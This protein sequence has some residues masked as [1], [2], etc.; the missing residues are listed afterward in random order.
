MQKKKFTKFISA[1]LCGCLI[2][3]S[4]VPGI[5]A[6]GVQAQDTAESEW[7]EVSAILDGYPGVYTM[8]TKLG[9]PWNTDCSPD[10]PLM[11]NG[12]VYAFMDPSSQTAQNVY[13][14]RS[15]LWTE[16]HQEGNTSRYGYTTLGEISVEKKTGKNL[17]LNKPTTESGW[18]VEDQRAANIVDG[19]PDTMWFCSKD[20]NG[21][22]TN[23]WAVVD[24]EEVCDISRWVVKHAEAGG[25]TSNLNSKDFKLQYYDGTGTPDGAVEDDW[26][27][28]DSVTDNTLA[29]TDR[30]LENPIKAR[31]VRILVTTPSQD[32][33]V[34]LR[35]SELELYSES[36]NKEQE[37]QQVQDV[38][39]AEVVA[40]S[41]DG[42][43]MRN[44]V[45][46]K[47]NVVVTEIKNITEKPLDL[48]VTSGTKYGDITASIDEDKNVMTATKSCGFD[49]KEK[50]A[51]EV[52]M[53]SGF[54]G[55][56]DIQLS[57]I[58]KGINQ[59]E[60][61]LEPNQTVTMVTAVEGGR[62]IQTQSSSKDMADATLNKSLNS[63]NELEEQHREWWK[64]YW[65]KS[66]VNFYNDSINRYYYGMLYQL[67]CAS[68]V[69]SN[70]NAGVAP[71]LFPWTAA[72]YPKWNGAYFCNTDATRQ[73]HPL[74]QANR[75]EGLANFENVVGDYWEPARKLAQD[76]EQLN[77]VNKGNKRPAFEEGIRGVL[78]T[79]VICPWG[80]WN[81]QSVQDYIYMNQPSNASSMLMPM[82]KKWQYTQ[83]EDYLRNWLYPK[84]KDV[85]EFWIDYAVEENGKYVIYG[86]SHEGNA[87]RNAIFDL[88]AA[89]Y[90]ISNTIEASIELGV[91]EQEREEWQHVLDNLSDYPTVTVNGKTRFATCEGNGFLNA[92]PVTVQG[93]YYFDA[94]DM[95]MEK[96]ERDKVFNYLDAVGSGAWSSSRGM[97]AAIRA[98]YQI[99]DPDDFAA[100]YINI[101]PDHWSG[102]RGN[103]TC[104]DIGR[105]AWSAVLQETLLQSQAGFLQLFPNW[106]HEGEFTRLRAKGAFL[107]DAYQ[108]DFD[109]V[110]Y[111]NV[112]SEKGKDCSVLNPWQ[113]DDQ[114][115]KVLKD[116]KEVKTTVEKNSLGDIY[117]F[118]TEAGANY[119]LVP[120]NGV[121]IKFVIEGSSD[122]FMEDTL[123]LTVKTTVDNPTVK[124]E[125]SDKEIAT[126]DANGVVT[127]KK[128][129]DVT[130]TAT[131]E[132]EEN[133]TASHI[134]HIVEKIPGDDFSAVAD[135]EENKGNDGPASNT[136][137]GD[138]ET[139]WHSAY[140]SDKV[141]PDIKNNVNN[142]ITI[143]LGATYRIGRLDYVP[144]QNGN[145]GIITKYEVWCSNEPEGEN[146]KKVSEGSWAED[147]TTKSAQ[148]DSVSCRRIR[149]RAME[150]NSGKNQW[151]TAA[152]FCVYKTQQDG[153]NEDFT[154][155][156]NTLELKPGMKEKLSVITSIENPK[157]NWASSN[158]DIVI[159]GNDGTLLALKEGTAD[160]TAMIAEIDL[161]AKC[162]V[163]V[164][165]ETGI[166]VAPNGT[167]TAS[168]RSENAYKAIN[169]EWTPSYEG[170]TGPGSWDEE[171]ARWLQIDLGK[172]YTIERWLLRHDGW[173]KG[174][175]GEAETK[176]DGN[177]G[178]Y[179]LQ[180][181]PD[182]ENN[183][184][185]VDSN[186]DNKSNTTD[187]MLETPVTGRYFRIYMEFP[188]F[189][190]ETGWKWKT[191]YA[192][193][194]QVELYAVPSAPEAVNVVEIESLEEIDV[195]YG[196]GFDEINLPDFITV[197]LSNEMN[198]NFPVK[199]DAG[200][201]NGNQEGT[202][203]I[204]GTLELP[205]G[206]VN[207]ENLAATVQVVV[208]AP[209]TNKESL[210]EI[211][212]YALTLNT[213]GVIDSAKEYFEKVL[214]E[215]EQV[216]EKEDAT[217]DE[218]DAALDNLQKGIQGLEIKQA[219]KRELKVLI[220][221]AE[222][223]KKE[224]SKYTEESVS[225]FNTA[226]KYA[227]EVMADSELSVKEQEKVNQAASKLDQAMKALRLKTEHNETN[228][229]KNNDS[230]TGQGNDPVNESQAVKTGD[231]SSIIFPVIGAGISFICCLMVGLFRRKRTGK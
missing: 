5:G 18:N 92:N 178:D 51:V 17:A 202:Y 127:P 117:T 204:N 149:L 197:K 183:W 13:L 140:S 206:I 50:Y 44:Y 70:N 71:G 104:G 205:E 175:S 195:D 118:K 129:G 74:V 101:K 112:Y 142:S 47:E 174:V 8:D 45:T 14:S 33:H 55:N 58:D 152:E 168:I 154:L 187:R 59:A 215:A 76:P 57:N 23:Y 83:D 199:W 24:L 63:F 77:L 43:T 137:D 111:V 133:V 12:T 219:D 4:I 84:M 7:E 192:R 89:R 135:S 158:T 228:D 203:A 114:A 90:Y 116:G 49:D 9:S 115:M 36:R 186:I 126:V 69:A 39:N 42:F 190:S 125:S 222:T 99:T 151:I 188:M 181:S 225:E 208:G 15:D 81:F 218:I 61:C 164:T 171:N 1:V 169:G 231:M 31:Y 160:I 184:E 94:I 210:Q 214:E 25:E 223:M 109:Q 146:F 148:F 147:R 134:V 138:K 110:E 56:N 16:Y 193:L 26:K 173:R 82:V 22:S 161:A 120:E 196:T 162:T 100:K 88:M 230:G 27:D 21:N 128:L 229:G 177:W 19:N 198:V 144:R 38:K 132:G 79:K 65:L 226:L 209:I 93:A 157:V 179:H 37:F 121:A 189:K 180:V 136:I 46:A 54:I 2:G 124:W 156:K 29:V 201:Y 224:L 159:V 165:K 34:A 41:E 227:K 97:N 11:G 130:I 216:L 150:T 170:W 106:R 139:Y 200:D 6:L 123:Q 131:L 60:M 113:D 167:A 10:G 73:E 72:E 102:I 64:E 163:T 68:S 182:G 35:L 86:S 166:N 85:T 98:G 32:G 191:G 48:V 107:V 80:L 75:F 30:N 213:E 108:N 217:Q 185:T 103:N 143:D 141:K 211:Y 40:R 78:F 153:G 20:K 155:D 172:E 145:N 212:N 52:T 105:A 53:T 95:T 221:K 67:G 194:N 176:Y 207:T 87:G 66:Y 220:D 62:K 3:T 28:A 119:E 91:D 96:S 122:L